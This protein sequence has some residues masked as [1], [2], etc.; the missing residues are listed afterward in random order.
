MGNSMNYFVVAVGLGLVLIAP[1][2]PK[3]PPVAPTMGFFLDDW[4]AKAFIVPNRVDVNAPATNDVTVTVDA[5]NVITKI[6]PAIYGHN[7]DSWVTGMITDPAFMRQ[8]RDLQPHVIRWPAG[9]G[10]D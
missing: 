4:K 7:V 6:P 8:V 1:S 5:T 10:S 3:D 9:S 2:A